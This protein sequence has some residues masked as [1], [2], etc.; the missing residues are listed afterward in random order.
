MITCT[1]WPISTIVVRKFNYI[2][3]CRDDSYTSI[4]ESEIILRK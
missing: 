2:C 1:S 3:K 4:N